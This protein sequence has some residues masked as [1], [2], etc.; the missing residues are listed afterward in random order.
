MLLQQGNTAPQAVATQRCA[1]LA[2]G[3][4][5]LL[6]Q[7]QVGGDLFFAGRGRQGTWVHLVLKGMR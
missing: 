5:S 2:C 4:K 3:E 1:D 7:V 6:L